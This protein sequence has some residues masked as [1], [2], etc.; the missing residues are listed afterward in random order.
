MRLKLQPP[1][2]KER[3]KLGWLDVVESGKDVG[4]VFEWIDVEPVT[5]C[6]Q[7]KQDCNCPPTVIGTSEQKILAT[8]NKVLY[9]LLGSIVVDVEIGISQE[10]SEGDPVRQC[11]IDGDHESIGWWEFALQ[12]DQ[13]FAQFLCKR[14]GFAPPYSQSNRCWFAGYFCFDAIEFAIDIENSKA[15]SII[16]INQS[17]VFEILSA[18]VGAT[19]HLY[20][21]AILEKAVKASS[22]ICLDHTSI[23]VEERVVAVEGEIRRKVEHDVW[24]FFVADVGCHLALAKSSITRVILDIDIGIIGLYDFGPLNF[25]FHQFDELLGQQTGGK[26]PITLRRAG[27]VDL[28]ALEDF[29]LAIERQSVCQ[30]GD[31]RIR[32]KSGSD[33]TSRNGSSWLIGSDDVLFAFG[34]RANFLQMLKLFQRLS[35]SFKLIGDLI[36]NGFRFDETARTDFPRGVHV[37]VHWL[38]GQV[39]RQY[40]FFVVARLRLGGLRS[41]LDAAEGW[42]RIVFFIFTAEVAPFAFLVLLQQHIKFIVEF[43]E[44]LVEVSIAL[45]R[46]LQLRGQVMDHAIGVSKLGPQSSEIL[47]LTGVL[48]M[49]GRFFLVA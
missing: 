47:A 5:C 34:A 46:Q 11:V 28:F 9:G 25:S 24:V 8:K 13:D 6:D 18:R 40:V 37:V 3:I 33:V 27:N 16:W 48:I 23:I 41:W 45:Q 20:S 7:R 29:G 14:L 32:E 22:S 17:E 39:L 12:S 31:A 43:F 30:L 36:T 49:E 26:H 10:S 4:K 1:V 35:D 38:Y 44:L 21:G 19:A 42:S 2:G 15:I